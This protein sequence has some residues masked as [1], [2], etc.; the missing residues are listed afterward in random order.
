M[1]K[2]KR[3]DKHVCWAEGRRTMDMAAKFSGEGL[4]SV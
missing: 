4:I 3:F 2:R 1:K